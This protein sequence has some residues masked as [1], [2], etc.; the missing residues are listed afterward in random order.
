MFDNGVEIANDTLVH[1]W[2]DGKAT[3][4]KEELAKVTKAGYNVV[5]SS[6][7]YLNYISYGTDWPKYYNCDPHDFDG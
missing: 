4:M 3:P 6:C 1:I 2:K 7:W 5:L